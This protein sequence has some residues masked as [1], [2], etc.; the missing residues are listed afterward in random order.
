MNKIIAAVVMGSLFF[1]AQAHALD[2]ME[3]A[4]APQDFPVSVTQQGSESFGP[5]SVVVYEGNPT[6]GAI[7]YH[8]SSVNY[9]QSSEPNKTVNC[10]YEHSRM[11]AP[12]YYLSCEQAL[13]P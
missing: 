8:L 5:C 3:K 12:S 9:K 7:V 1:V 4:E 6:K 2:C 10:M 13:K 11:N